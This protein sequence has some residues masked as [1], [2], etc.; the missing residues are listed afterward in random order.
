MTIVIASPANMADAKA[1]SPTCVR[2]GY[3]RGTRPGSGRVCNRCGH[4]DRVT[5]NV[6][7]PTELNVMLPPSAEPTIATTTALA[8]L[9]EHSP[10][11]AS[12]A[13]RWMNCPGS[14]ALGDTL[15]ASGEFPEDDPEYRTEGTHAHSVAAW[16]LM[17]GA[18]TW[19]AFGQLE[20]PWLDEA[21]MAAVQVYVDFVKTLPGRFRYIEHRMHRPAFHPLAYG[22]GDYIGVSAVDDAIDFVDLKYGE[23][24]IVDPVDNPQLMYY[25]YLFIGDDAEY[26]DEMTVRLHICQPRAPYGEPIKTW[27]V[28]AGA[29]RKWAHEMLRPAMDRVAGER[30]L[31]VGEWCRFC[32]AKIVCPAMHCLSDELM[33]KR[34]RPLHAL[35]PAALGRWYAN[36]QAVKM[37]IKS[38]ERECERR[39]LMGVEFDE[40][41][42][43]Q[44]KAARV[45]KE[46]VDFAAG[47]RGIDMMT[48]PELK[49]PAQIEELGDKGKEFVA[50]WAY[51]PNLGLTIAP[52]SDPRH[53]VEVKSG[54][55]TFA[56]ALEKLS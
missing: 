36:A 24:I 25:A 33:Y 22:T 19:E 43:V 18:D 41:K 52:K 9:P 11:G 7:A 12:S 50:E 27:E 55:E 6:G 53:A 5:Y 38:I 21:M 26:A 29:I 14:V 37:F 35:E 1:E 46:G 2:H 32:P 3:K 51:S 40:L 17:N 47:L 54:A 15:R 13:E 49:S 39:A 44:K 20:F 56:A 48:I 42:V 31:S 10:L 34:T 23:G 4:V 28:R 45:W 16:C 8:I 30:Y